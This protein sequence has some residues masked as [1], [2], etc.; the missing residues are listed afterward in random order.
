MSRLGYH[1]RVVTTIAGFFAG[2]WFVVAVCWIIN[3][4]HLLSM[5]WDASLELALR[6]MGL[7]F[8]FVSVV[9]PFVSF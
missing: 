9:L 7:V 4:G 5:K 6:I 3:I 1:D 8:P 2:F